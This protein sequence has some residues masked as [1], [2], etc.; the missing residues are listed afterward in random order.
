[1][2]MTTV[3]IHCVLSNTVC[4]YYAITVITDEVE[5]IPIKGD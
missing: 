5:K 4:N 2:V 1:M 3:E